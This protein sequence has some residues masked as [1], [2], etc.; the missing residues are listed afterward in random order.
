MKH[1]EIKN[2]IAGSKGGGS[3]PKP[4]VLKPPKIGDY[5]VAASFSYSESVD[6][7]SDGPIEGLVNSNGYVLD[8]SS[9]MQGINLNDVQVEVTNENFVQRFDEAIQEFEPDENGYINDYIN[10]ISG[11]HETLADY[12]DALYGFT[13]YKYKWVTT[14]SRRGSGRSRGTTTTEEL[15][16]YTYQNPI[17][18]SSSKVLI[19]HFI[20]PGVFNEKGS[21]N[22]LAENQFACIDISSDEGYSGTV[23][24]YNDNSVHTLDKAREFYA[25]ASLSAK[26]GKQKNQRSYTRY[27]Y[28]DN[29]YSSYNQW[30]YYLRNHTLNQTRAYFG[31]YKTRDKLKA[32]K[33]ACG[34]TV[35]FEK[36]LVN[37]AQ[38]NT[39]YSE[40]C[41]Q[42]SNWSRTLDANL[43][44][45][46]YRPKISDAIDQLINTV[47]VNKPRSEGLSSEYL[48]YTLELLGVG[49]NINQ[50]DG[51]IA[52]LTRDEITNFVKDTLSITDDREA[53]DEF[54][55]PYS[56]VSFSSDE[57][58]EG[59]DPLLHQEI[60]RDPNFIENIK[61][62]TNYYSGESFHYGNKYYLVN[63]A[64]V[65]T[66]AT[67]DEAYILSKVAVAQIVEQDAPLRNIE[68]S[69]SIEPKSL[70]SRG[71]YLGKRLNFLIPNLDS[72]G[73]W[74]GRVKGFYMEI[75]NVDNDR[76][77]EVREK[78][79]S[80]LGGGKGGKG[81]LIVYGLGR[82]G[83][84]S[85][86]S[87]EYFNFLMNK[88]EIAYNKSIDGLAVF[89]ISQR[90]DAITGGKKYNYSNVMME[91]R[92][93]SQ[94]Q[95]PL[96]YFRNI[97]I[98]HFYNSKLIGPFNV[99][100]ELK[101]GAGTVSTDYR[102][103]QK[104]SESNDLKKNGGKP[105]LNYSSNSIP[106][107]ADDFRLASK[108][109]SSDY[110]NAVGEG[111]GNKAYHK[112][113][114]SK[115]D[116]NEKA[117]P[118]T[119]IIENPNTSSCF[120]TISVEAL[121]DTTEDTYYNGTGGELGTKIPAPVNIL[122]ETGLINNAGKESVFV[123]KFFQ[124]VALVESPNYM[125][126]GNPDSIDS[127]LEYKDIRELERDVETVAQ[128]GIDKPFILPPLTY[129]ELAEDTEY[130]EDLKERRYI[131]V[132]KLSTESN[133]TLIAKEMS[134]IKVTEIIDSQCT[135]PFSAIVGTKVDSRVFND[136]PKRTYRGKF[137]K[138][139]I[140][141]NYSPTFRSGKDKRFYK[142]IADFDNTSNNS[143]QIYKGDWD[144]TFR[145][146]WSDNPAWILYDMLTSTR[147]GLGE[148]IFENQINKWE[149][150]SI[151][152]FCDAVDEDGFFFGSPD[153]RGGLEPRF[154][155]NIAFSQG[156]KI[157]DAINSI[158]AI[159]RGIVYFKNSIISFSDDRIK[160]PT[161][162]FTNSNVRD[163]LF[164]YSSYK[165][166]E[167]FNAVEVSYKDRND[168]YKSKTEYVENEKDILERGVFK[169]EITAMGITSKAMA[170]RAAKH[171]MYQTTKE[172]ESVMFE[173]GNECLLCKPGDL[174][175][176]EDDLK[177][178]RNNIGRVLSIDPKECS[179][180]TTAPF[181]ILQN[182][183]Q[184]TVYL[185]TGNVSKADLDID[186][187]LKRKRVTDFK[188]SSDPSY[189]DFKNKFDSIYRFDKYEVGYDF[190]YIKEN[191]EDELYEQYASY[192]GLNNKFIWFDTEATGWV[193]STGKAFQQSNEYNLYISDTGDNTFN[194]KSLSRGVSESVS[195]FVYDTNSLNKRSG[196]A[197]IN[198]SGAFQT[199]DSLFDLDYQGGVESE[200]INLNGSSQI[201]TFSVTGWGGYKGQQSEEFGD[202]LYIDK[203]DV[204]SNLLK[205]IPEGSTYRF[206]SKDTEDQ[207][208]KITSIKENE[209]Y[210]YTVLGSKYHSGKF[211]EIEKG[212]KSPQ[213][214]VYDDYN[215][216]DLKI[217]NTNYITLESPNADL[218]LI[219]ES[220]EGKDFFS[221]IA[222]W[223]P[224]ENA[225][226]YYYY[227]E[228][229]NGAASEPQTTNN[230]NTFFEPQYIG[231]HNFRIQALSDIFNNQSYD[232]RFYDS[233]PFSASLIVEDINTEEDEEQEENEG[234]TLAGVTIE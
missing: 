160:K 26:V 69:Y 156:T 189:V 127:I 137:K 11:S 60:F 61:P 118:I 209:N 22:D 172:N 231:K 101:G 199:F 230:T 146:A 77:V 14:S 85:S 200:K 89:D 111:G 208:F 217:N 71:D 76:S 205:F 17:K 198:F 42:Y 5:S 133:S 138:I 225:T 161:A 54:V 13:S 184:V 8:S 23:V 180:R 59:Y 2:S 108:E 169:K 70:V 57:P 104:L 100:G 96:S 119:H 1:F 24:R 233:E 48:R 224:V 53:F 28:R 158:A 135:Y 105:K 159:F 102:G 43:A 136:I 219:T 25:E 202:K 213:D 75:L 181:N 98:D 125:D 201:R 82:K 174:I 7:I 62:A 148:Q 95:T 177:S 153:D 192:T 134:L 58:I 15:K 139:K 94:T 3:K 110:R 123:R 164:S 41:L 191:I 228:E 21:R 46:V 168:D 150:Y 112:W 171:I 91:F 163:G 186:A 39:L 216:N 157:F 32:K 40:I 116:Y 188:V 29:G 86:V 232:K 63:V 93:G 193:F 149:L 31:V 178:L 129:S 166:D 113:N 165:R 176:V 72:D 83:K 36:Q 114:K 142:T 99:R 27:G 19:S 88:E 109:G 145:V 154:N 218:T 33:I 130:R 179:I 35:F 155:C 4:P 167:K 132:T 190:E 197:E 44:E 49:L 204:N 16:Q 66:P 30:S 215:S 84:F 194:F 151:G 196:V 51:S 212:D 20:N 38:Q 90:V 18:Q 79:T 126:I 117:Q 131:R 229:P 115:I 124:V 87:I 140:P 80:S 226:G 182:N 183:S 81:G 195:G 97:F 73:L 170:R 10:L 12:E 74:N 203:N 227:F 187:S 9:Y 214:D 141:S 45:G 143:K 55:P 68:E 185:P 92:N 64:Q 220:E 50:E 47:N 207:V 162:L 222:E 52:E 103:V 120:V 121:M 37:E 152:R 144:G 221:L 67:I 56:F 65:T 107:M 175:I 147:Y 210:S 128:G 78:N 34:G 211:E 223:E 122:V 234:T 6:L 206:Q 106:P 173:A